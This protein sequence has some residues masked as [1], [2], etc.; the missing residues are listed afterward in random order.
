VLD[1]WAGCGESGLIGR[2]LQN[3]RRP[4]IGQ[5]EAVIAETLGLQACPQLI[6]EAASLEDRST[7]VARRAVGSYHPYGRI[8]CGRSSFKRP[9]TPGTDRGALLN[10]SAG[11]PAI[12]RISSVLQ[13]VDVVAQLIDASD[14]QDKSIRPV[15][16]TPRIR[17]EGRR[18]SSQS[19]ARK[20][21]A[22]WKRNGGVVRRWSNT[23]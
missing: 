9:T 18:S 7:P 3:L 8:T 15:G 12:Q 2:N 11:V 14:K 17:S 19:I 1:L 16:L 22:K 10:C 13:S 23:R 20:E 5:W 6:H 4:A 21:D